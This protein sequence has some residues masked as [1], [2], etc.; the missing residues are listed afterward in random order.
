MPLPKSRS[1]LIKLFSQ[2]EDETLRIIIAEVVGL[3]NENR[4]SLRFPIKKVEAIVDREANLIEAREKSGEN[5]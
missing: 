3:E 2:I 5:Q 1:K 4:S